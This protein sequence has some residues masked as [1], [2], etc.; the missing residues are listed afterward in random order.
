MPGPRVFTLDEANA[1]VSALESA[2]GQVDDQRERLRTLKIKLSALEM[3]WG[4]SLAEKDCPD[5]GEGRELVNQMGEVEASISSVIQGLAERGVLV[6]EVH[7]GLSDVYHVREG[8]LVH[9]CWKRGEPAFDHWH[10]VDE[11][12]SARQPV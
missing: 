10:H 2:F 3:I 6:K 4:P 11:G 5:H 8:Q 12:F 1:L 7:A 9:L